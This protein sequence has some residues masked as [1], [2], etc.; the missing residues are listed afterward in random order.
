MSSGI[1]RTRCGALSPF[2]GFLNGLLLTR[3]IFA[4]RV[5]EALRKVGVET[6]KC[7]GHSFCIIVQQ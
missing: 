7:A 6:E 5:Q 1:L 2:F 4:A 3:E